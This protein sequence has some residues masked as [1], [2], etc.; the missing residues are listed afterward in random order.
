MTEIGFYHLT[1]STDEQALPPLLGRTLA[2]GK[3]AVVRCA[4][5]ARVASVDAALWQAPEPV[6]LPHG[7][8]ASGDAALQPIWI[9]DDEQVPNQA[10][11]LF[12]V[13]GR[14]EPDAAR[15][16][17]IFVLFDGTDAAAVASARTRWSEAKAAGHT[18]A[19]WKQ[20]PKGWIRAG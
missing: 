18:L 20:E 19:Y 12:L 13:H 17:R 4:D 14:V 2:A 5:P 6:W 9:T 11:Y 10:S 8:V 7:S 1:R 3:R 16:E 15:F